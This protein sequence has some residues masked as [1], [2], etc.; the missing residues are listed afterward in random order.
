M[1]VE[2]FNIELY[3][4]NIGALVFTP[5][6]KTQSKLD[7]Y[8]VKRDFNRVSGFYSGYFIDED[9]K[10]HEFTRAQG[11]VTFNYVQA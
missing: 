5:W 4:K 3:K 1:K 11:Y 7:Y 9:S 10:K 8:F 6:G 2:T